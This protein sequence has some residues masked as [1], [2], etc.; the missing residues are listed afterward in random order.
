MLKKGRKRE[1]KGLAVLYFIIGLI[2][3]LIILFV[4]FK[5]LGM[6][7]S[8][9][10]ENPETI[11]AF[12]ENEDQQTSES[13]PVYE[14]PED[15]VDLTTGLQE[16][17]EEEELPAVVE[18]TA[19]PT[20]APTPTPEPTA[21]PTDAPTPEPTALPAGKAAKP[22]Q[23][24]PDLPTAVSENGAIGIT[25]CYVSQ[26]DDSKLMVLTGY[27]YV[28]EETFDADGAKSWLVISQVA[29]GQKLAYELTKAPGVTGL[30]HAAAVCQNVASS[31]FE[32]Y[33]DVSQY[34]EGIYSLAM[35]IGYVPE[36]EKK[37]TYRYYTFS[38]AVSFNIVNGQVV[39]PVTPS[40]A[41]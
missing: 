35:V 41:E 14:M 4:I 26:A 40:S 3:L 2:I 20:Q 11:R 19:T 25:D 15:E 23:K 38:G 31:D 5:A 21:A 16:L 27:G 10:V 9:M 33:L 32:I 8:D 30:S 29:T 7:Y 39:S 36:G 37:V 28:D 13:T 1:A 12:V 22:M 34:P 17:P 6:N 24:V 18:A